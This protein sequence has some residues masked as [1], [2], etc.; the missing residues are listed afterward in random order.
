MIY[1]RKSD[2]L[3]PGR[4]AGVGFF[5]DG[6]A[7]REAAEAQAAA[8]REASAREE[9]LPVEG[10]A[11]EWRELLSAQGVDTTDVLSMVDAS[12]GSVFR[13]SFDA[14]GLTVVDRGFLLVTAT[15]QLVFAFRA[16]SPGDAAPSPVEVI[17]RPL[18]DVRETRKREDRSFLIVFEGDGL[19]RPPNSAMR[20]DAW[21][22]RHSDPD[23]LR[24]HFL[25]VGLPW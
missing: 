10:L 11:R 15:D 21:E 19:F 7:R 1:D 14:S 4:G 6:K 25:S 17:V 5:S 12:G 18:T 24:R 9:G 23:E 16:S 2:H 20:G 22:L 3:P 13:P 8:E